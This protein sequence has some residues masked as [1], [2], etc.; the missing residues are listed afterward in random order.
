[1]YVTIATPSNTAGIEGHKCAQLSLQD[2][3]DV[4]LTRETFLSCGFDLIL[5]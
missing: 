3:W 5:H 2:S 1:M 4:A